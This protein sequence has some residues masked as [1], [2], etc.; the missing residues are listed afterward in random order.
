MGTIRTCG[1]KK[2]TK[3][4]KC[5]RLQITLI[6]QR[7]LSCTLGRSPNS[8]CTYM[9]CIVW[10]IQGHYKLMIQLCES[11]ILASSRCIPS[12]PKDPKIRR[13]PDWGSKPRSCEFLL[14][15]P[16]SI[17]GAESWSDQRDPP[18]SPA[19]RSPLRPMTATG[20]HIASG[21]RKRF[22]P[23]TRAGRRP[24]RYRC[25]DAH[26]TTAASPCGDTRGSV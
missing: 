11:Q 9:H 24:S 16:H 8:I 6:T 4:K 13:R 12:P 20:H 22:W 21:D 10:R 19:H 14:G 23:S 17:H 7:I 5:P 3:A 26:N 15:H 1:S 2:S 18:S 25:V